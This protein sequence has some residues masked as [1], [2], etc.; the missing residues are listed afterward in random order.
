MANAITALQNQRPVT[1]SG[2]PR[3]PAKHAALGPLLPLVLL[4]YAC[5]LPQEVH[6]DI[7]GQTIFAYRA[8]YL[9]LTPWIVVQLLRRRFTPRL[10]DAMVLIASIWIV[11]SFSY[12]YE[13]LTGVVRGSALALD[14]I[15][16]Y[17]IT[18]ICL[19]SLMDLRRLLVLAAPGLATVTFL[20]MIE[21]VTH[22]PLVRPAASTIFGNLPLYR[23]GVAVGD[24]NVK[25]E[26]RLGLMRAYGPFSHPILAGVLLASFI[27]LYFNSGLRSWP[28]WLGSL[29]GLGAVFSLSSA[30][31]LGLLIFT[32]LQA[33]R[34]CVE[35]ISFVSWKMFIGF[36]GIALV[37]LQ[38][39]TEN[40]VIP[41]LGQFTLNPGTAYYRRLI[42]EYGTDS[43]AAHPLFGIGFQG[44]ERLDWMPESVDAHWLMLA[45]RHGLIP[46]ILLLAVAICVIVILSKRSVR[47]VGTDRRSYF[48][49][50]SAFTIIIVAGFTVTYFGSMGIW[51]A[52]VLAIG[53]SLSE[54]ASSSLRRPITLPSQK[55]FYSDAPSVSAQR[56]GQ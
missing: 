7:A 31:F 4:V 25:S 1:P 43:V 28:R 15:Y 8:T 3:R 6:V 34:W 18:R 11:I 51:F 47:S 42:W 14:L 35:R 36:S 26:V 9:A 53:V 56:V 33:Y 30:A 40:G 45:I 52:I 2:M 50:I 24:F 54:D 23:D 37:G 10:L 12:V 27:P 16:P 38:V 21:S 49:V 55:R 20:M 17:L 29:A 41:Y 19:R 39:A 46:A 44:Y 32:G 13:G 22:T 5:L 48:G